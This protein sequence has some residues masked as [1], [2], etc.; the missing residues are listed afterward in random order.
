MDTSYFSDLYFWFVNKM[1][2]Q[3]V[4][5]VF[6]FVVSGARCKVYYAVT[7]LFGL[8]LSFVVTCNIVMQSTLIDMQR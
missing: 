1:T 2:R 4:L 8:I 3:Q 6:F 7:H 5:N